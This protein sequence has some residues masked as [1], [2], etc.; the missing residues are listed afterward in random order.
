MVKQLT[1]VTGN[2]SKAEQLSMYLG[3]PVFHQKLDLIEIQALDLVEVVIHK[4]LEAYRQIERPVL[5]D[6]VG[7]ILTAMGK[8][9]GPFIKFFIN[10][11]GNDG[12]CKL[13]T[14]FENKSATAIVVIGY[15]DGEGE[16][17]VFSG[18]IKGS[19]SE[20]P[21]GEGGFGWDQIFI[22]DEYDQTRAEMNRA[23][24]DLTSPRKDALTQLEIY[25]KKIGDLK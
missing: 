16:V 6:D 20:S 7:L 9:P 22:P 8:L 5:V 2:E 12:I 25:L 11:L 21:K 4:A 14:S 15:Y 23:D 19:I 24:Y 18:E 1:F 3:R 13:V 17:Q 10:E